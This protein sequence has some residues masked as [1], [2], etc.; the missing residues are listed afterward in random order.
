MSKKKKITPKEEGYVFPTEGGRIEDI[1]TEE[2][3]GKS[4]SFDAHEIT[5]KIIEF[6]KI[7]TGL[8]L[9]KYQEEAVYAIIYSIITFSGDVKTMLFSRQS[10]KCFSPNTKI[11]MADMSV[12]KIKDVNVGDMVMGIGGTPRK[13]IEKHNGLSDMYEVRKRTSYGKSYK[14]NGEHELV[15]KERL[16]SGGYRNRV[17]SVND[18]LN[19]PKWKRKDAYVGYRSPVNFEHKEVLLDPYFLGIWLGDGRCDSQAICTPDTPV[20]NYLK[21]YAGKLGYDVSIYSQGETEVAH[22]Y[23][24]T[25]KVGKQNVILNALRHYNLVDNKHIPLEYLYNDRDTRLELLA[26]LVDSDGHHSSDK[27]KER[28]IEITFRNR[29]LARDVQYLAQSLG[30]RCSLN[31]KKATIKDI[32]FECMVYRLNLYGALWEI[33][34]KV[35]RK[36]VLEGELRENPLHYGFDVVPCGKGEFVG[37]QVDRDNLFL[38]DD[39]TVVHNS[40]A[41]AFVIDTLTVLLPA[42][43]KVIPD[44]E[45]FSSGFRIGLFA[46]QSDQVVTTYSRAMTR[47]NSANAEMVLSD[48]D[49]DVYLESSARLELSNGSYLAGQVASKQSKIESKTYDLVIV[50]EAQDVDDLIV[51]KCYAEDTLINLPYGDYATIKDVVERKLPVLTPEGK[52]KPSA[53]HNTGVQ[54]VY[55][56]T[57]CNGRELEV[58]S[59]HRHLV[60]RRNVKESFEL[61]TDKLKVGDRLAVPDFTPTFGHYGDYSMG[62]V[63][64]FLLGDGCFSGSQV[65]FCG[66]EEVWNFVS[67]HVEKLGCVAFTNCFNKNGLYEGT[68]R[69]VDGKNTPNKIIGL[70][71]DLGL[72]GLKG[73]NKFIPNL[74]YSREFLVG[75]ICGLFESDGSVQALKKG[76]IRYASISKKLVYGLSLQLQKFGI[77][78]SISVKSNTG[79]GVY[80]NT[81]P[82]YELHIRDS[83]SVIRFCENFR[84]VTKNEKLDKAKLIAERINKKAG[85]TKVYDG[86]RYV[87]IKSIEYTGEK[88][89]YC[90]TVPTEGHWIIANGI[91][92]GNSIEPMLSATGGTLI[93][94]GTTGMVKNHF[95]YEIQHNKNIDRKIVDP[96]IKNH[97]EYDYKRII[98]DRRLQYDIDHKRFHLNYEA[99][100]Q[101]KKERWGEDSQAFKLAYA[102]IWDLESGML[103]S[104]K[105]YNGIINRKLGLQDARNED[106]VVAGLDIGKHPAE[107]VLTIVKVFHGEDVFDR[108]YKQILAWACLGGLDYESQHHVIMD[109]IVEFN[110]SVIFADY[111]GVGKPVVDR[112]MYACGEYVTI[113]PYTFTAQSK[114]DMWF[115]FLSDIQTHHLIVP[116]NKKTRMTPEYMKFEEQMKNCQKYYNGTYLVCEKSEGYFDDMVDSC[117]LAC[118]AAT[119]EQEVKEEMEVTPN[120]LYEGVTSTIQAIRRHSF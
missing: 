60:R 34:S 87:R 8:S 54:G 72:W 26:G 118:M 105:E 30:F 43:A 75:L 81:K 39:F 9:Y 90:V 35:E 52:M 44:L 24:I 28:V 82:L 29:K 2:L 57:L 76:N 38:L 58:T 49:I 10:G 27:G 78:C 64:G 47:I 41:M 36:K 5:S 3:A 116:A 109:F 114:S 98:H 45:Q 23:A 65:Q 42:L 93:K 91:V 119:Y 31:S 14:V 103:L 4:V 92:S 80:E 94:V 37:I 104:D 96:R 86:N 89:T 19:E 59:Q 66:F 53:W 18:Y 113:E 46:P 71:K 120:P 11:R 7:L 88:Q 62:V 99:D 25:K 115:N 101:R 102:L 108:P 48:P 12:R 15:F 117:A 55:K 73:E 6:G 13:V 22:S 100:I 106:Y 84:L 97:F 33:P 20:I 85:A 21:E 56:I 17:L 16:K 95:W 111:T 51:Q 110:I 112:L 69:N 107:T 40:E 70:L 68:F 79:K 1:H 83:I 67:P 61:H 63:I 50:E 74:P 32:D 77:H